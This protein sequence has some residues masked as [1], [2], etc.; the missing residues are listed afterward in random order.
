MIFRQVMS[1]QDCVI[2]IIDEQQIHRKHRV[3][4]FS[5]EL[6][7]DGEDYF[8]PYIVLNGRIIPAPTDATLDF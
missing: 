8:I 2:T 1:G 6:G 5:C 3:L 7:D 4:F